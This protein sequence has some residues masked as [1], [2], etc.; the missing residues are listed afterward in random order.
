M[1]GY[2]LRTPYDIKS[3]L[4]QSLGF[5]NDELIYDV[6]QC[7]S[8]ISE[9]G[10]LLLIYSPRPSTAYPLRLVAYRLTTPFDISTATKTYNTIVSLPTTAPCNFLDFSGQHL[11]YAAG[12][13]IYKIDLSTI[14]P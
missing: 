11:F 6:G 2:R 12:R 13:I 10:K 5:I 4:N 1:I 7:Y 9:D 8:N 14:N 3:M